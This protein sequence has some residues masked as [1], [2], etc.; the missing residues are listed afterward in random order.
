MR[1]RSAP[2][3]RPPRSDQTG[4]ADGQRAHDGAC[5]MCCVA[6]AGASLD[7]PK[8]TFATLIRQSERCGVA[9]HCARAVRFPDRLARPGSRASLH[10]LTRTSR[11]VRS[12]APDH[13]VEQAG[14]RASVRNFHMFRYR[15]PASAVR[16]AA[17]CWPLPPPLFRFP[18]RLKPVRKVRFRPSPSTPLNKSAQWRPGRRSAASRAPRGRLRVSNPAA[19]AVASD[20]ARGPALTVLTVQQ[21]LRDIQQTPGGVAIVPAEAY[22]NST[23]ANTIKDILDYVPGRLRAAQ[24]GRRYQALDP[25]FRPV[26][27][28]PSAR[29][30]ALHG[31]DSDQHRRRLRRFPGDRSHRLQ[32]CRGLQG[33]Q[34]TAI[35][36]QL[37]GRRHQFRH[38]DRTRSLSERRIARSRR[39]RIPPSTSQC[40]RHQRTMG[41]LHYRLHP[42]GR[43]VQGSQQRASHA[44]QRQCRLSVLA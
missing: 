32:I 1:R 22:R 19:A 7:T 26:A 23:V 18:P 30:P 36:R 44:C 42:G 28:L 2:A 6:H 24:M 38:A 21:A 13:A 8:A 40:G 37:A 15:S 29:R 33:R 35:R 17:S 27:Q 16:V 25:R 14:H 12:A 34:C 39:V 43:G 20:L 11:S 3:V 41:R 5:A 9:R 4:Q 31:R 10:F